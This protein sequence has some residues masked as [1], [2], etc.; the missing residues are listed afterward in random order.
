MTFRAR[1]QPRIELPILSKALLSSLPYLLPCDA[2]H[3]LNGSNAS[4]DHHLS[5]T[6][7]PV[8]IPCKWSVSQRYQEIQR[9]TSWGYR[10]PTERT[11]QYH[12]Q[13]YRRYRA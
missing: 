7:V 11:E 5:E 4:I 9:R 10:L 6:Q 2:S 8:S 3:S 12:L 1:S 13:S